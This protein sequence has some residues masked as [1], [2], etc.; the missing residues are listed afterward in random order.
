MY[1]KWRLALDKSGKG[2]TYTGVEASDLGKNKEEESVA[3]FCFF[4]S[5]CISVDKYN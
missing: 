4:N 3:G 1:E 5:R 2:N